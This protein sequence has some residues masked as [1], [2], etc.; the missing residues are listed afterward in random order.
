LPATTTAE[1]AACP[2]ETTTDIDVDGTVSAG[3]IVKLGD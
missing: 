1:T 2:G 3:D